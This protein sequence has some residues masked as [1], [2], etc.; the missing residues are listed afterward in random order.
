MKNIVSWLALVVAVVALVVVVVRPAGNDVAP[1]QET[2]FERVMRT[3][4]IRC[5]YAI[6]S[7][8]LFKDM[9]TGEMHGITHDIMEEVGKKLDLRIDWAEEGGWGT[10][11][12]GLA[13]RRYDAICNGMGVI[14]TRASAIS[15]ST[16]IVYAPAYLV[17]RADETR[18]Q[19]TEDVNNPAYN[20]AVLEGEAFS[21][22]A[23]KKFPKAQIKTLPQNTDFSLVFQEVETGK[24]DVTGVA[25]SDFIGYD[26]ANSGKLKIV[27][28][29]NPP[30]VYA[31]A[32]GLPQ[33]DVAFKTMIDAVL[34]E[35]AADGAIER[36]IHAY[37]ASPQ[38]FLL[39]L[40]PYAISAP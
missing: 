7:P 33:G 32:F 31:M 5:G 8:V 3:R 30:L 9:K 25:Y 6:W 2:A 24:A 22:L 16:P 26:K 39:P 14:G 10:I 17:V 38:E 13:T 12:E 15:F 35:L 4:T 34:G 37:S 1:K 21:Y 28:P 27:D 40:K 19:K 18:I 29:S 36:A 11:V 23:P 20:V